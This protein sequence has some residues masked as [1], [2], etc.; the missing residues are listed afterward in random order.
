MEL[1]RSYV[2]VVHVN[3]VILSHVVP[4]RAVHEVGFR[5]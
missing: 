5:T 4:V 2:I 3:G 1:E